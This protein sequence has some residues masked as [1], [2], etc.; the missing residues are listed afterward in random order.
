MLDVMKYD[1][2]TA[3]AFSF[4]SLISVTP[5]PDSSLPTVFLVS[6]T[7]SLCSPSCYASMCARLSNASL[8]FFYS[9]GHLRLPDPRSGPP[10]TSSEC[11]QC[12][13]QVYRGGD[14]VDARAEAES[15]FCEG[16]GT[17]KDHV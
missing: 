5:A 8:L 13:L 11:D 2:S 12:R 7:R 9:E 4:D 1:D 3:S 15:G 16:F 14:N 10:V 17:N 6:S